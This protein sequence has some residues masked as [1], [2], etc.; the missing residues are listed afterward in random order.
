MS[1]ATAV[2]LT[3]ETVEISKPKGDSVRLLVSID[4]VGSFVS[5][6][7]SNMLEWLVGDSGVVEW[8]TV[9]SGVLEQFTGRSSDVLEV[10]TV[11][12]FNMI[13]GMSTEALIDPALGFTAKFLTGLM[14]ELSTPTISKVQFRCL[15]SFVNPYTPYLSGTCSVKMLVSGVSLSDWVLLSYR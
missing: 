13:Y 9:G 1:V 4:M 7:G 3:I 15:S 12:G 2:R 6:G 10:T 8:L 5:A 14:G 11:S